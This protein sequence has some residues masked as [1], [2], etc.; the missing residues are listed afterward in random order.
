MVG[1]NINRVEIQKLR[2]DFGSRRDVESQ[3]GENFDDLAGGLRDDMKRAR[4]EARAP[5]SEISMRSFL[6]LASRSACSS[7]ALQFVERGFDLLLPLVGRRADLRALGGIRLTQSFE[8]FRERAFF[9][10]TATRTRSIASS[11]EEA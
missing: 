5:G 8:D 2:L 10:R 6:S 7:L 11:D 4:R 9:P 3:A 1:G